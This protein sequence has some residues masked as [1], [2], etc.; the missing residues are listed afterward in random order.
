MDEN[1]EWKV[2]PLRLPKKPIVRSLSSMI[3]DLKKREDEAHQEDEDAMREMEMEAE[4]IPVVKKP[5]T[6]ASV[7]EGKEGEKTSKEKTDE[8]QEPEEPDQ[9]EKKEPKVPKERPVLLGGFDDESDFDSSEEEQ[10]DRGQPLRVWK[11]K[12]QKRTTRL[13]KMKPTRV[14]RPV[15]VPDDEDSPDEFIEETQ[16]AAKAAGDGEA[17]DEGLEELSGSDFD[18]EGSESEDEGKT[19][20]AKGKKPAK[21]KAAD[22]KEEKEGVVKKAVRMVKASANA[23]FK[24][25]K[26]RNKGGKAG[27]GYNSRFRRKR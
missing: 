2:A 14:K 21:G 11:K 24:R 15:A 1:G 8:N 12:G 10:L 3:A 4:G 27:P 22:K 25:L 9:Q 26:L 19:L 18:G 20:K 7:P 6:L 23:N 13:T 5:E 17:R 16:Y